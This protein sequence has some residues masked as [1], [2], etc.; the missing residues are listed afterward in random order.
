MNFDFTLIRYIGIYGGTIRF[1]E[2]LVEYLTV[3]QKI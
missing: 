1:F 3:F 2:V